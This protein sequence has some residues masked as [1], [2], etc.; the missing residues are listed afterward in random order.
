M[1]ETSAM[2]WN[3]QTVRTLLRQMFA[4]IVESVAPSGGIA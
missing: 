1:T 2:S 3:D 4:A